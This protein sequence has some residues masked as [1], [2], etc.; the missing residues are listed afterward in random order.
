MSINIEVQGGGSIKLLTAG[1]YCDRDIV[2]TATGG[3][4]GGNGGFEL[5]AVFDKTIVDMDNSKVTIV[6]NYGC[7][8]CD[9][10]ETVNLPNAV[11][12]GEYAFEGCA[13]LKTVNLPNATAIKQF[14]FR[15]A[16]LLEAI[17]LP[18][19]VTGGRNFLENAYILQQVDLPEMTS[20]PAY[21]FN[22]CKKLVSFLA[23]KATTISDMAFANCD[24]LKKVVLP[25]ATTISASAFNA[26]I[27]LAVVDLPV[28]TSIGA[29]SF[30]NDKKLVTFILRNNSVAKLSNTSAF[31]GTAIANGTGYI[32]VP[33]ALVDAYKT[34][35]NWATYASRFRALED[36]TVDGTTSGELDESKI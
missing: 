14:A 28:A 34:A 36:Y 22:Q 23:P 33:A 27:S 31:S 24:V 17:A 7:Q 11:T 25:A 18:K 29:A 15:N 10:L 1:K 9:L 5:A 35:T 3:S 30:G 6:P 13:V 21:A 32:Y 4:N 20:I 2:V 16:K 12:I 19:V 8:N 26:D